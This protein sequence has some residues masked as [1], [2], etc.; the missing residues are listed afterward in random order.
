MEQREAKLRRRQLSIVKDEKHGS[1]CQ[2]KQAY[3]S[4]DILGMV[5]KDATIRVNLK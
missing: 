2:V 1:Y 4:F 5:N 3:L